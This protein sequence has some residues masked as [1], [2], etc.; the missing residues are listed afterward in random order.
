[1]GMEAWGYS[2]WHK[3]RSGA[4]VAETFPV[5]GD[6]CSKIWKGGIDLVAIPVPV[7]VMR[8]LEV[9]RWSHGSVESC[10]L[11]ERLHLLS[12]L[13]CALGGDGLHQHRRQD[14]QAHPLSPSEAGSVWVFPHPVTASEC[15]RQDRAL[16]DARQIKCTTEECRLNAK[17]AALRENDEIL[18]SLEDLTG[19]TDDLSI[20]CCSGLRSNN[21]L[22]GVTDIPTQQGPLR[23][24]IPNDKPHGQRKLKESQDVRETLMKRDE[25]VGFMRIN[26]V[27]SLNV[28]TEAEAPADSL[29]PPPL[30][31]GRCAS[32]SESAE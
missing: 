24:F 25:H 5:P 2:C 23:Q 32:R 8:G 30:C 29:C 19:L 18:T 13:F 11:Q 20:R 6:V 17:D 27:Q 16:Q 31:I 26:V 14:V 15:N 21:N 1:M 7:A 22:S 10:L 28:D 4:C 12:C 9:P 3:C